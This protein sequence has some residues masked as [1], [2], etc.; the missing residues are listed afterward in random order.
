MTAYTLAVGERYDT[1]RH[2]APANSK[3]QKRLLSTQTTAS[4]CCNV[5]NST[6]MVETTQEQ[7]AA[8]NWEAYAADRPRTCNRWGTT[9]T[10]Y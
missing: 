1:R 6:A 8:A 7:A 9:V 10:C 4:A 3:R 5:K 2:D